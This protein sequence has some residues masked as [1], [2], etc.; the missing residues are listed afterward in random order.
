MSL[1]YERVLFNQ[2]SCTYVDIVQEIIYK[3]IN[4]NGKSE[5]EKCLCI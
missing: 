3:G 2:T 1:T 4:V 5:M